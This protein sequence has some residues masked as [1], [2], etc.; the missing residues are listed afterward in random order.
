MAILAILIPIEAI[1]VTLLIASNA[2][3]L[4]QT[5]LGKLAAGELSAARCDRMF[6]LKTHVPMLT[7]PGVALHATSHHPL[8][9]LVEA[10][11]LLNWKTP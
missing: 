11:L 3:Q 7:L 5:L 10:T 6:A 2:A 1:L 8:A 4:H 9:Q